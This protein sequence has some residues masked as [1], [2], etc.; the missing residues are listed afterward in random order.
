MSGGT[1]QAV[2]SAGAARAATRRPA[3]AMAARTAIPSAARHTAVCASSVF[4]RCGSRSCLLGRTRAN[5]EHAPA[6]TDE[7]GHDAA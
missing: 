3:D 2:L 4:A 6:M 7:P 5:T 1:A